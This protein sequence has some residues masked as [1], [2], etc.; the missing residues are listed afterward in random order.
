ML[1]LMTNM[2]VRRFVWELLCFRVTFVLLL[3]VGV[4]LSLLGSEEEFEKETSR[5]KKEEQINEKKKKER[6]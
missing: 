5:G 1:L 3:S 2:H 6:F 4:T